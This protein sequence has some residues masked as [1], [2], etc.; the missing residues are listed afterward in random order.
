MMPETG[1][2]EDKQ[3]MEVGGCH[4][5]P[6]DGKKGDSGSNPLFKRVAQVPSPDYDRAGRATGLPLPITTDST[7]ECSGSVMRIA[8]EC[9]SYDGHG[10]GQT[11]Q[12]L[13]V[14]LTSLGHPC[15]EEAH[16]SGTGALGAL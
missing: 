11:G 13:T 6:H 4:I 5:F 9:Q 16:E 10:K 2:E 1:E 8:R 7:G 14:A 12:C 15:L 3:D